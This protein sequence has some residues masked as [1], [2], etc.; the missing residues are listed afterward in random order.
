MNE[1]ERIK[2]D[3]NIEDFGKLSPEQMTALFE[4][5]GKAKYSLA[6]LHAIA[7]MVPHFSTMAVE[8]LHTLKDI[9]AKAANAHEKAL[10][11]LNQALKNLELVASHPNATSDTLNKVVEKSAE[12]AKDIVSLARTWA[13]FFKS[14][15]QYAWQIGGVVVVGVIG[16]AAAGRSNRA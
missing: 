7:P 13:D 9:T 2:K 12:I 15:G 14:M 10:E 11:G 8:A 1:L 6:S 3:L 4:G 16:I 5:V